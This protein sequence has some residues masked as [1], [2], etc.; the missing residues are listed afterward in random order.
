VEELDLLHRHERTG[1][2]LGEDSFLDQLEQR[3][4]RRLRPQKPG[5]KKQV[6]EEE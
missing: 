3:L 2:P 6:P 1:R 5:P 4:G